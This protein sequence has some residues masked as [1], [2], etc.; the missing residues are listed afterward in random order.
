MKLAVLIF[1]LFF[2]FNFCEAQAPKRIELLNANTLEYDESLGKNVRRLLGDVS[3]R[4][5]NT[6][7]YCDSAYLYADQNRLDAFNNIRINEPGGMSLTGDKLI[8][9]G[10]TRMAR[11]TGKVVMSDGKMVLVTDALEY[12]MKNNIA[13]YTDNG[14]ITDNNNILTSKKGYYYSSKKEL[15]FKENVELQNPNYVMKGDTLRY[16]TISKIAYFPGPTTITSTNNTI[17]CKDGWYDT[18]KENASFSKRAKLTSGKQE[19]TGDSLYYERKTGIGLAFGN[20]V[21]RDSVQNTV[22]TGEKARYNELTDHA[23]ITGKPELILAFETDSLFLHADTLVAKFDSISNNRIL[24]AWKNVKFFKTDL[25]GKS[26]SLTYSYSDSTARYY[27]N[28]VLWSEENQ[29]SGDFITMQ[30]RNGQIDNLKIF[31]SAFITSMEEAGKFNQIKGKDLTGY[32]KENQL[33]RVEVDGN[34]QSLYYAKNSK[35]EVVGMNRAD[36]SNLLIFIAESKVQ[37]ISLLDAP[38][39]I[40]YPPG[41]ISPDQALLKGFSWKIEQRPKSREDI[42][43]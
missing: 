24:Y 6:V 16:N 26:D 10:N 19:L 29:L 3:F 32:F 43:N 28:P 8:Y 2:S 37:S 30:Q 14:K 1:L 33:Y 11:I 39:A 22:I 27:G 15:Y 7:M 23:V 21:I 40:L 20:I 18:E 42:F 17:V 41:K 25:Q 9:D 36:C 12:D 4:H 31:N 34:G 38:T 5:E 13:R 35:D